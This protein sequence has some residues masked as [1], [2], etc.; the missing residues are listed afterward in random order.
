MAWHAENVFAKWHCIFCRESHTSFRYSDK[1]KTR[2][3]FFLGF[4]VRDL[5]I[6]ILKWLEVWF[7]VSGLHIP[8]LGLFELIFFVFYQGWLGFGNLK[9]RIR[10]S[11]KELDGSFTKEMIDYEVWHELHDELLDAFQRII[12]CKIIWCCKSILGNLLEWRKYPPIIKFLSWRECHET[13]WIV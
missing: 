9:W 5:H 2:L 7:W 3:H 12:Q 4:G 1:S 13:R 6:P 8:R 11:H 10:K